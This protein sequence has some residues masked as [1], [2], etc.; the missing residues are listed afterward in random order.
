MKHRFWLLALIAIVYVSGYFILD[1]W[2]TTLYYGD[3]N[4][5]YLHVVS[6]LLHHDVGDY[7]K[8][9]TTLRAT[10]PNSADPREDK[11]GIRLTDKGR[12]YIK[13]TV[14][15]PVMEAPFFLL[16][17]AYASISSKYAADGWSLPYLVVV[18]FSIIFYILVG[19]YLLIRVMERY[20]KPKIII[21]TVV[22]IALATNLF[23]QSTY[24]TMAHGFL[25]FDYCLLLFLTQRFYDGPSRW[26]ALAVGAVV[27]LIALT[28][29]PEVI[30]L[31]IPL[32][33][34]VTNWRTLRERAQLFWR[35][36]QWLLL[37]AIGFLLVFSLQLMYWYYVSGKVYFN[38]YEGE[39][40]DFLSP[41]IHKGWFDFANGW[42]IY[43]PIMAFSLFGLF[44]LK[45]YASGTLLAILAFVGLHVYIHYSYYAWTYF[46]GLGQR[47]MVE[48]YPLLAFGLAAAFYWFTER[49]RWM[50]VPLAAIVL[51][52]CLNLFQTWQMREGIIWS[53][54]GNA[55]F[56]WETFGTMNPDRDAL[57]AYDVK[58]L[59]PKREKLK[60]VDI[61]LTDAFEDTT[62]YNAIAPLS[63]S[64]EYALYTTEEQYLLAEDLALGQAA[65]RD[66]L[67]LA[68]QAYMPSSHRMWNRDQ[69]AILVLELYDE[70]SKRRKIREIKMS[71]HL[72]NPTHSIWSAGDPDQWGPAGYYIRLPRKYNDGWRAKLSVYNPTR[73][74]LYLDDLRLEV[75][76][77]Q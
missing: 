75:Y 19:F 25:F 41:K 70:N 58:E 13:Y 46:P 2:R 71:S 32:L 26:R 9:I 27:G 55:A 14:G 30:S 42:L 33:W 11:F 54:R 52:T 34:G 56:Y 28:R 4:G 6:F 48:T 35:N 47:P 62:G 31:L 43:T 49:R 59:Q 73:Q 8:S 72:G 67:H 44:H 60:L 1:R 17:H 16:A 38:P 63:H 69:C 45:K 7:D 22:A 5:Y 68:I 39:G 18:S 12:R 20:F 21:M 51:F 50:L 40:F 64:G 74:H 37:A 66:Y 53:E 29:V 15:V 61:V 36:Y 77:K 23:F 24:V 76:R 10:N 3:S 65:K 57:I